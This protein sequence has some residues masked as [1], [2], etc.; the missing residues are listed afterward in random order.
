MKKLFF[1]F[2]LI[3]VFPTFSFAKDLTDNVM[4]NSDGH[5]VREENEGKIILEK[6]QAKQI[7]CSDLSDEDFGALGEYFMGRMTEISHEA[8]NTMMEQMMGKTGEEQ[9]HT[10]MGKRLSG[11]DASAIFPSQGVGF[12]P[13]MTMMGGWSAR[14]SIQGDGSSPS[15]INNNKFLPMM[16]GLG[17][18]M[19]SW[20]GA[21]LTF[22]IIGLILMV[23]W[24][25]FVVAVIIFLVKWIIKQ[26][27]DGGS[28]QKSVLD[29]L[30]E[31]YAKGEIDKKEFE[32]KKKDLA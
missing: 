11:C 22:G 26:F 28:T 15:S 5:T 8:M 6:L 30:K 18:N 7:Q 2:I 14:Q 10:V 27:K 19:M 23:L 1:I 12:M 3:L 25:L 32:E 21:G 31:R 9:M 13:M 29:I 17:N 24:W 4:T 16:Y 20:G